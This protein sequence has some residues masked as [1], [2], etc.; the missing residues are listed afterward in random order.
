MKKNTET[1]TKNIETNKTTKTIRNYGLLLLLF[2]ASMGLV[3]YLCQLYKVHEKEE[4][5]TP[6][7][8]GMLNEIYPEDLD[9]YIL[10]NP[11]I[12]IYMCTADGDKCRSFEKNFVKLIKNEKYKNQITYL[13]L[14]NVDLDKFIT[15][16]NK[17]YKYKSELT[18]NYPAFVLYEDGEVKSILQGK[19]DKDITV[20]K[21]KQFIDL[22]EIGE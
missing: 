19:E 21:V 2:I 12:F 15:D 6:I 11:S 3:L 20:E 17:K 14:T 13:N 8:N 5:K 1:E 4:K 10:D 7:I 9:H 18:S 16:F 22:N